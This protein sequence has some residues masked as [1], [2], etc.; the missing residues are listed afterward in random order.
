MF[1]LYE[2]GGIRDTGTLLAVRH[3]AMDSGADCRPIE[4]AWEVSVPWPL[5]GVAVGEI[6]INPSCRHPEGLRRMEI[7]TMTVSPQPAR[8]LLHIR[9]TASTAGSAVMRLYDARGRSVR[10]VF[11]GMLQAETRDLGVDVTDLARGY[12]HLVLTT[13]IGARHIPVVL[14]K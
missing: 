6:C 7:P 2:P 13:P 4:L 12:Y 1:D 14:E 10:T 3:R 11:D 9:L 5:D 8:A